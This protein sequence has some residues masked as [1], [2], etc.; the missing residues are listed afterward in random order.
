LQSARSRS[1]SYRFPRTQNAQEAPSCPELHRQ[2]DTAASQSSARFDI[3]AQFAKIARNSVPSHAVMRGRRRG[4]DS[5][6]VDGR[7]FLQILGFWGRTAEAN[8]SQNGLIGK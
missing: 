2:L 7:N 4:N 3:V 8:R 1:S 5:V 6:P